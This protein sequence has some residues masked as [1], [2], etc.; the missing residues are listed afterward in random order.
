VAPLAV[1]WRHVMHVIFTALRPIPEGEQL[2]YDYG[3]DYW[4]RRD[5]PFDLRP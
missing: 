1:Y 3:D 5:P 4:M 2:L